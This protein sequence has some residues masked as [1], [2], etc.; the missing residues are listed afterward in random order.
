MEAVDPIYY[1]AQVFFFVW[2]SVLLGFFVKHM[3][4]EVHL[5]GWGAPRTLW[6]ISLCFSSSWFLLIQ[7]DPRGVL[8]LFPP[9]PLKLLEWLI[10]LSVLQSF[11]IT[12]YMYIIAL[13]QR[14]MTT[15]PPWLRN[16]WLA[17]NV[18]YTFVHIVLS[19]VGAI[20]GNMF[21]FGVDGIA[22]VGHEASHIIVLNVCL[23]KL[24]S[25]LH[26]LTQ[27]QSAIGVANGNFTTALRKML[28]VR[29]GSIVTVLL[30]FIYQL[31][32]PL[33]GAIAYVSTPD[34]P[35][36]PYDNS[37]FVANAVIG[38]FLVGGLHCLFLYMLSRPQ[39]KG[40][41]RT[42]QRTPSEKTPPKE[43]S[44]SAP[45]RPSATA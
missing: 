30:V 10:I 9:A 18:A 16:Y 3:L 37:V 19:L 8:G 6:L 21:W 36:I 1:V 4:D 32:E 2:A 27:E 26:R 17:F 11:A 35:I 44:T 40:S 24:S 33:E 13:Y 28:Y 31:F 38:F 29:V 15:V 25:Y 22:L 45:S 34:T 23:S 14:N 20:V 39:A 12:G 5:K 41:E 43:L 42:S 7:L